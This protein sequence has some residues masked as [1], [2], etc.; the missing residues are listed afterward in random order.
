MADT[1]GH[2]T[3]MTNGVNNCRS[4]REKE[5]IGTGTG[6]KLKNTGSLDY[7]LF[8]PGHTRQDIKGLQST[9]LTS[10]V[11]EVWYHRHSRCKGY[12]SP[13]FAAVAVDVVVREPSSQER[14]PKFVTEE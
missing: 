14:N 8:F 7:Q 3:F 10:K 4:S 11:E 13:A 6:P 9:N 2:M 1:V 5:G 12:I